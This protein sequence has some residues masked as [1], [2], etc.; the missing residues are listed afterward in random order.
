[1]AAATCGAALSQVLKYRYV[2]SP[3]LHCDNDMEAAAHSVKEYMKAILLP[4]LVYL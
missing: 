3:A 2:L 1:M 4:V